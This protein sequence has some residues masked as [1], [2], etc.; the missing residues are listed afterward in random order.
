MKIIRS[1]RALQ[2][3]R[4]KQDSEKSTIGF[5]PTMGAFHGGHQSLI[6]KARRSCQS[7]VVS[8]FVNP[9]QFGPTEDLAD[10]P[11]PRQAD[12]AT[13][14]KEGVD[15]VFIPSRKELYPAN[16]QTTVK[17]S[18]LA[19]RWEGEQR[20]THFQ[21]VTTVVSKLLNLV[22]PHQAYFGQKDYQQFCIIKQLVKDL[23]H[24]VRIVLCPT[25]READGLAL[26]SRNGYLS[27]TARQTA[28]MLYQALQQGRQA[29]RKG[30]KLITT[31]EKLMQKHIGKES[32]A[33]IDYLAVCHPETLE[34]LLYIQGRR[35]VLLGA[36]RLGHVRLI[37]NVLVKAPN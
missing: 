29:I 26:S 21:G 14:R 12:M 5:V 33:K 6:Q 3:W 19:K 24:D 31:I 37:D 18:R 36:I 32:K 20:N 27:T 9:L 16:F 11:R 30:E 2:H 28:P 23:N 10:Y 13:C 35:M 17:V 25:I 4:R 22:R 7:V 8:I 1:V 34:P 15:V